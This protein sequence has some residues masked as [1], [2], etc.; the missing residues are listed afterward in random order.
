MK[1]NWMITVSGRLRALLRDEE[2]P[3]GTE[4]AIML[5]VLILGCMTIIQSIGQS[6]EVIYDNIT[7][8]VGS[9]GDA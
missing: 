8:A 1:R 7:G 6:M 3:T 9:I 2:G 4:Y 5:A